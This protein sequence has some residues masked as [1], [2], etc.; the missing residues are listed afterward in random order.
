M[1][2][3]ALSQRGPGAAPKPPPQ[4]PTGQWE[5]PGGPKVDSQ[6]W[7]GDAGQSRQAVLD[8]HERYRDRF[9]PRAAAARGYRESLERQRQSKAPK[10][11]P[12][13]AQ[14]GGEGGV[15]MGGMMG[16]ARALGRGGWEYLRAR[17]AAG[18][19]DPKG[20]ILDQEKR[21]MEAQDPG[22]FGPYDPKAATP[23]NVARDRVEG[24]LDRADRDIASAQP[25]PPRPP[26]A[27]RDRMREM[28][29]FLQQQAD[30]AR[31]QPRQQK[32]MQMLTKGLKEPD[33]KPVTEDETSGHVPQDDPTADDR[34]DEQEDNPIQGKGRI[35]GD[36]EVPGHTEAM[37]HA[38]DQNHGCKKCGD[39]PPEDCGC[40]G[41]KAAPWNADESPTIRSHR[42][43][44][45]EKAGLGETLVGDTGSE[46]GRKKRRELGSDEPGSWAKKQERAHLTA[47]YAKWAGRL[48]KNGQAGDAHNEEDDED[49]EHER[50]GTFRSGLW[51]GKCHKRVRDCPHLNMVK[52]L[53]TL[54]KMRWLTVGKGNMRKAH[55]NQ[56]KVVQKLAKMQELRKAAAEL[57]A[58]PVAREAD[59]QRAL[60]GY[61]NPF[62][63]KDP[64]T[65]RAVESVEVGYGR[66][67]RHGEGEPPMRPP[68]EASEQKDEKGDDGCC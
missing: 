54:Q 1:P 8:L 44:S 32:G 37:P 22:V 60:R 4:K 38:A 6:P 52:Q 68:P 30:R 58:N 5:H 25:R 61:P 59:R 41:Q 40:H 57:K 63:S 48:M 46:M 33:D 66:R 29:D 16:T 3:P 14:P 24:Q 18:R 11:T 26:R 55:P 39:T 67:E 50:R 43:K 9:N 27:P 51:C 34:P 62:P 56:L 49:Y 53:T 12:E 36:L 47:S 7:T 15:P 20:K 10:G 42:S 17:R 2:S 64:A 31:A 35:V 21:R 28:F 19:G 23:Q 13:G 65:Q 45:A